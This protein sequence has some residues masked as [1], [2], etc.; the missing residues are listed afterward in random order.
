MD[1]EQQRMMLQVRRIQQGMQQTQQ[2]LEQVNQQINNI[3]RTR[4]GI[5]ELSEKEQQDIVSPIGA[6]A[7]MP[8]LIKDSGKLLVE[9][10]SG[11]VIEKKPEQ[12]II[13]LGDRKDNLLEAKNKL[14]ARLRM[15]QK[16]YQQLASQIQQ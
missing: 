1:E 6:G 14:Q 9:I 13:T 4:E 8:S 2:N 12:A 10:G 15:L 5:E 3:E 11:I 16:Q 7:Y